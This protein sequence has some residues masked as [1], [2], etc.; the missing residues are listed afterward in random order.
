MVTLREQDKNQ[1]MFTVVGLGHEQDVRGLFKQVMEETELD[2]TSLH[3][4]GF[5]TEFNV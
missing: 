4:C 1:Y 5:R 3:V 2:D